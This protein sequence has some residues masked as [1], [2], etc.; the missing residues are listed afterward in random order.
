[1]QPSIVK[2][3]YGVYK[4]Y[5]G[6]VLG[7]SVSSGWVSDST[8]EVL[9]YLQSFSTVRPY[10]LVIAGYCKNSEVAYVYVQRLVKKGVLQRVGR[11]VYKVV[12]EVIQ[13]LLKLPIRKI[14]NGKKVRKSK[15][16]VSN[17]GVRFSKGTRGLLLMLFLGM[18]LTVLSLSTLMLRISVGLRSLQYV[19]IGYLRQGSSNIMVLQVQYTT[20][21]TSSLRPSSP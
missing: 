13:K 10:D 11:G 12:H 15:Q 16:S 1:M 8:Y 2:R 9:M 19:L 18:F 6:E 3:G 4:S 17:S 7:S 20:V 14:S 5:V 21:S